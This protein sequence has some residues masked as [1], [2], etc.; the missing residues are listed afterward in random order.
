MCTNP[1]CGSK[2][3]R[4]FG[5]NWEAYKIECVQHL[6]WEVN[7]DAFS[8]ENSKVYIESDVYNT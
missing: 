5:S 3:G 8:E 6:N 7:L 2:F 1:K 4:F